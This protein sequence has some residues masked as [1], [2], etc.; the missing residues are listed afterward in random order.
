M[1][2]SDDP[3]EIADQWLAAELNRIWL[4]SE[5]ALRAFQQAQIRPQPNHPSIAEIESI[6][7]AR[8]VARLGAASATTPEDEVALRRAIE[9]AEAGLGAIRHKALLGRLIQRLGLRPL[10]VETLVVALAPHVDAPLAE[11]F[12]LIRGPTN[13]RRGVDLALITQLFRLKRAERVMLL[14]AVDPERPLL[15]W[16]LLQILTA[17]SIESFTSMSHR[18]L[19]PTFDLISTLCGRSDLAPEISPFATLTSERATLDDLRFEPALRRDVEALCQA[20]R[21]DLRASQVPWIV[22]WG[23]AGAGKRT[24]A[25]RIAAHGGRPL[26][27]FDPSLLD[28]ATF[29][30]MFPR[31]QREALIR[32]ALLYIGPLSDEL[33]K[34]GGRELRKRVAQ[35]QGMVALGIEGNA[36]P[37]LRLGHPL[38][39]LHVRLPPEPVRVQLWGD[40]LPRDC[41]A[42]DLQ[43]DH[44]ARAF[45]L[46][47]GEIARSATEART[48]AER[49][50]GRTVTHVDLRGGVER[51]LRNDLGDLAR[52]ITIT[53][54]W[55]DLV[56]PQQDMDRVEEFISRKKFG[57]V[58]YGT[59]GFGERIGY[60]K[61]LIALFSGP[62]G[63]GKTM[64]A[65]L[66]AQALDLDLYQID[67]AQ[68][69]SKWVG[70]TE[71]HLAKVFEQAE[72]A[73]AVLLFDEADSL[74]AKR[75]EVKG[76][77][78]RYGN[79][80]V[81]YLLQQLEQYTGVAVLTTNKDSA[82]DEALQRRL[83]LHLRLEIPEIAERERLWQ[84]FLPSR[85][86]I[87]PDI[88]L[89]AL[90]RE[91]ELSGG[92]IKNAA[93]RAAFLAASA[94]APIGME[95]LRVASALELEDMGRVVWHRRQSD[96]VDTARN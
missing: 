61:G 40:A 65:G 48:I 51:L 33:L 19:R 2:G 27:A 84:S 22:L 42:P 16:K 78:D 44:I 73:H 95:I 58:V 11:V 82:L 75:T 62:P 43:I 20:A 36:P 86:P 24:I 39:E 29:D 10:E 60:G 37:R 21:A 15:R 54:S 32:D 3:R 64:L 41:R 88:D 59:W 50:Q 17:E 8:R 56:L 67:I 89:T 34:E 14:D 30:D 79:M 9:A 63:T 94:G 87:E 55:S 28:R 70:E 47:P 1:A 38:W 12:N 26:L 66:I 85:A 49:D 23:P 5:R 91:F 45:H 57:Q 96:H 77:N 31:I 68:V 7:T 80:A 69:V 6:F 83:T 76:A 71:K 52:R 90:A 4:V 74:F 13:L 53:G 72:R 35:Y 81:N 18:A 92:Y 93:V 25:S 46:S